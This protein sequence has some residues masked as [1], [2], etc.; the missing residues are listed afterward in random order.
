MPVLIRSME[1]NVSPA[2]AGIDLL[3]D[4]SAVCS[5]ISVSPAHAG[6]DR[7]GLAGPELCWRFPRTR[8]DRPFHSPRKRT[9]GRVPPAHAG[10]DRRRSLVRRNRAGSP[11]HAGIDRLHR[12][13]LLDAM[14]VPPHTRGLTSQ[15][16]AKSTI[17]PGSPAH[18]GI[19]PEAAR[20][21]G[22][23]RLGSPAHAG[24]DRIG[25]AGP[26][27][28]WRFPRT[29]GDRPHRRMEIPRRPGVPPHTRG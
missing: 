5:R 22:R 7:I 21:P 27:L 13:P 1:V 25:L 9:V 29:R 4:R 19:D 23:T 6:I 10:I 11:A 18:A 20:R 12:L 3:G 15:D 28:C 8:G 14:R 17:L 2:H 26:E 24:I 16:Y